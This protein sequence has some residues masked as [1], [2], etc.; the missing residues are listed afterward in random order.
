MRLFRVE[1]MSTYH[2]EMQFPPSRDT[3]QTWSVEKKRKSA[4]I[5]VIRICLRL[6]WREIYVREI[7]AALENRHARGA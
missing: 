5:D 1:M 4:L 7:W 2:L 6:L 3:G